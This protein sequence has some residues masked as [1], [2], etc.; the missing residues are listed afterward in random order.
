M[1]DPAFSHGGCESLGR[2]LAQLVQISH[3]RPETE[4][5]LRLIKQALMHTRT[6]ARTHG[7]PE[8]QQRKVQA[9]QQTVC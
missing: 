2:L 1:C 7:T 6:K 4:P 9:S 8:T 5:G 3:P